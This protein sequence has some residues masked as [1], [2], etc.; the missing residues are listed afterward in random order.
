[1]AVTVDVHEC[2]PVVG[3]VVDGVGSEVLLDRGLR[4]GRRQV[5][6]CDGGVRIDAQGVHLVLLVGSGAGLRNAPLIRGFFS[7]RS[8]VGVA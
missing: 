7:L 6:V 5:E 2:P 4:I 1:M 3:P 8:L